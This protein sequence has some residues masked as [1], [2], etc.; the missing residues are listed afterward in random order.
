MKAKLLLMVILLSILSPM[1]TCPAE[2]ASGIDANDIFVLEMNKAISTKGPF[3]TWSLEEK[4]D[5]YNKY[6][7]HNT[8]TRRGVPDERHIG[9]EAVKNLAYDYLCSY[10]DCIKDDLSDYIPDVDF[11]VE[12]NMQDFDEHEYYSVCFLTENTDTGKYEN[13]YQLMISAYTDD[14]RLNLQSWLTMKMEFCQTITACKGANTNESQ[15]V[16]SLVCDSYDHDVPCRHGFGGNR[17][18]DGGWVYP[19]LYCR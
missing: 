2:A 17:G 12:V 18:K 7:Y 6:V 10:L 19:S 13:T 15:R 4:A 9:T 1:N 5:F 14:C 3:Y 8:G 11:W 16:H